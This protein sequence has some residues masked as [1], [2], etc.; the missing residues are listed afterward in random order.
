MTACQFHAPRQNPEKLQIIPCF[1]PLLLHLHLLRALPPS[2]ASFFWG[3]RFLYVVLSLYQ[4]TWWLFW[5]NV[6]PH[7]PPISLTRGENPT[8]QN[9]LFPR[10]P[11]LFGPLLSSNL[12]FFFFFFFFT[13]IHL[14]LKEGLEEVHVFWIISDVLWEYSN[15]Y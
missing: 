10:R 12:Y 3:G 6:N 13:V 11:L 15:L 5:S 7:G 9:S 1:N 4:K 8:P 14:L 2:T